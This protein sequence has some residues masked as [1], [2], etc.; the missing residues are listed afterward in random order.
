MSQSNHTPILSDPEFIIKKYRKQLLRTAKRAVGIKEDAEDIVEETL[1]RAI[2]SWSR[3]NP[4]S[5]ILRW[6]LR[7]EANVIADHYRTESKRATDLG[8]RDLIAAAIENNAEMMNIENKVEVEHLFSQLL[9]QDAGI[10][11]LRDLECLGWCEIALIT[12]RTV[13]QL[14]YRYGIAKDRARKLLT[15]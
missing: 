12:G 15:S 3:R 7:I 1:V 14:K 8:I 11:Y 2:V 9:P 13:D 4:A 6:L 5:D 10:L